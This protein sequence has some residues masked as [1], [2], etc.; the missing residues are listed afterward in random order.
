MHN[1]AAAESENK[2]RKHLC[3]YSNSC[4]NK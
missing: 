4:Y 3:Q 1:Q 2:V